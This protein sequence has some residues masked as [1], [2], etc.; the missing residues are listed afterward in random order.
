MPVS[1]TLI[2]CSAAAFWLK[3]SVFSAIASWF[4]LLF[5]FSY[6]FGHNLYVYLNVS[7]WMFLVGHLREMHGK[8]PP[9][10]CVCTCAC[11]MECAIHTDIMNQF[12]SAPANY[13][14]NPLDFDAKEGRVVVGA[15]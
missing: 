4:F 8:W 12:G 3:I 9:A 1:V 13:F 11:G 15:A 7:C 10:L 6:L 2:I 5:F 14:I